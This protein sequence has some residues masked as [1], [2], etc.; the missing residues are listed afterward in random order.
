MANLHLMDFTMLRI[1][2]IS[3]RYGEYVVFKGCTT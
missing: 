2:N 3:K 1:E